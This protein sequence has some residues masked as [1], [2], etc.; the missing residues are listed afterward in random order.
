M[1]TFDQI[2][3][4]THYLPER[5]QK[6]ILHFIE[7]TLA[8]HNVDYKIQEPTQAADSFSIYQSLDLGKGGYSQTPSNEAK[9]GIRELLKKKHNK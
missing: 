2:L 7:Y 4:K 6:E 3:N 1:Q 5:V 8:K 9:Q